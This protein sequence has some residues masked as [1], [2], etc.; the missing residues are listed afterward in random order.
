MADRYSTC[1]DCC[2]L[3]LSPWHVVATRSLHYSHHRCTSG[4]WSSFN[5][6]LPSSSSRGG[7]KLLEAFAMTPPV[8]RVINQT[9]D[10]NHLLEIQ[11]FHRKYCWSTRAF[12][13]SL[14]S[15]QDQLLLLVLST[16]PES[17]WPSCR[18][19]LRKAFLLPLS[20]FL[21]D[22]SKDTAGTGFTHLQSPVLRILD[23]WLDEIGFNYLPFSLK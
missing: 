15:G 8:C 16:I 13:F 5:F 21:S 6:A 19:K 9:G 18:M 10:M 12:L 23:W 7:I 20:I 3:H 2:A 17:N 4:Q 14:R 11:A 1:Y 22:S